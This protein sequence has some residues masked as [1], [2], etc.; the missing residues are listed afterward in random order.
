MVGYNPLEVARS[1]ESRVYMESGG[2]SRRK[3]FR[4]RIDRWYGGIVTGDVV[5]CNMRCKF[6][7]AWYFTWGDTGKGRF[8]TADE[9][10][11]ILGNL[12]ERSGYRRARLSGGE[13][14]IGFKHML[15]VLSLTVSRGLHFVLETNGILIGHDKDMAEEL[16]EFSGRGIEVRVSVKGTSPEEFHELTGADPRFWFVQLDSLRNLVEA[17]L[18]PAREVYPAV[19]LSLSGE[20]GLRRFSS[21]VR[22]IHRELSELIDEEY[23]ILYRHVKELMKRTGLRPRYVILPDKI[24]DE[25]I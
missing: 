14:T 5:G 11:G 6:C 15:E 23:I 16:G 25:L 13:P 24:P 18:E 8:Y 2:V 7:W 3:Y 20:E 12:S 22:G 21:V 10:V 17:G 1:V 4:F 9:V 19:M